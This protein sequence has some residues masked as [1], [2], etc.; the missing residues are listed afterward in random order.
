MPFD[1]RAAKVAHEAAIF[2]RA[3]VVGVAVGNKMI[4]GQ[5]TNERCIVVFV[6]RKRPE[7]ELRHHD[8]VPKEIDGVL[9]DVV[10]SGR[11]TAIPL[12]QS[13]DGNRTH[14]MRPALGGVSIGHYRITAGGLGG[15]PSRPR[16]TPRLSNNPPPANRYRGPIR[17]SALPPGPPAS[18]PVVGAPTSPP[19][20]PPN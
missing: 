3:N 14:R 10:E 18:G 11:F 6:E 9:T 17:D 16:R 12:V 13:M 7:E 1:V 20:L 8:V 19:P 15:L 4:H 2:G 5:D